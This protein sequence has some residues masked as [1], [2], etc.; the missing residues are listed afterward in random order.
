MRLGCT[1]LRRKRGETANGKK[2][3]VQGI[4]P[5]ELLL[6]EGSC[7]HKIAVRFNALKVQVL[8]VNAKGRGLLLHKEND[9]M[10][11]EDIPIVELL[12]GLAS[13]LLS[14]LDRIQGR[15]FDELS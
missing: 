8:E 10:K 9:S 12:G 6:D 4:C 3:Q 7:L 1:G 2:G 11:T 5:Y 15:L 13:V 14:F